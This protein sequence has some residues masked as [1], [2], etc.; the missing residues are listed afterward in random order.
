MKLDVLIPGSGSDF[1]GIDV[2]GITADSRKVKPGF[3]FA[4]LQGVA[5]DGRD[6]IDGAI[7]SGA[8]AILT[9]ARPGEWSVPAIRVDEPRLTL[10][11]AA[12]AFY[13]MQ[14]GIVAGG[15]GHQRQEFDGRF[16]APDLEQHGPQGSVHGHARCD[17]SFGQR[18]SW[19]HDA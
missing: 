19:S 10:A 14:P 15:D 9:D 11:Q 4:A 16:P 3:V 6:Y 18:R 2:V 13:P 8:V 5:K 7:K 12:A 1:S 17:R